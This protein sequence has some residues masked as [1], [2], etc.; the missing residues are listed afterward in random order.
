[1]IAFKINLKFTMFFY[2]IVSK[3][4][5]VS[6]KLFHKLYLS[7]IFK[8]FWNLCWHFF[9]DKI[10]CKVLKFTTFLLLKFVDNTKEDFLKK[11]DII[12]E[13][14]KFLARYRNRFR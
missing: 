4:T 5:F 6:S 7:P 13:N 11:K 2:V 8:T 12:L 9:M 1:M 10:V 14:I 3:E